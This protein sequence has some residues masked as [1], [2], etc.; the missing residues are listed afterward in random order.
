MLEKSRRV[1]E[2]LQHDLQLLAAVAAAQAADTAARTERRLEAEENVRWMQ[3]NMRL[4]LDAEMQKERQLE[5][6][7][8]SVLAA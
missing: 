6:L 8:R 2:E 7:Y 4:Q 1:Q 3:E 5:A